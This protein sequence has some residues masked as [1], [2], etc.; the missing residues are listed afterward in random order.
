MRCNIIAKY[1]QTIQDTSLPA[2]LGHFLL[3]VP[4]VLPL[5]AGGL[6]ALNNVMT[7]D[8]TT[9]DTKTAQIINLPTPMLQKKEK[10]KF[11]DKWSAAVLK[12]GRTAIPSI[13]LRRQARLGLT[14]TELNV[15]LRIIDHWWEADKDSHPSKDT[16]ARRM[17]KNPRQIQRV[18]AARAS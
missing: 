16:I 17:N 3:P 2:S 10:R 15:L 7:I 9:L 11:E 13:L 12:T 4:L 18:L 6:A 5:N 1:Y 14:S 8:I